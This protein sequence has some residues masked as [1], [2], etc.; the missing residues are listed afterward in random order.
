VQCATVLH[1]RT[2]AVCTLDAVVELGIVEIVETEL[3]FRH[4]L[5]RSA[6]RQAARPAQ[7]VAMYGALA[8]TVVDPERQL[9]HR[10][11]AAVG[12]DE[13]IAVALEEH[14]R[15]A[16]RRGAVAVAAAALERSA[17]LSLDP[18]RKG[19]R[20]VRAAEVVYELG[21]GDVVRRV[22]R[23]AEQLDLGLLEAARLAWL[24]QMISGDVWFETG[25]KTFVAI[26]WQMV[27]RGD[28]DM[29]LRS[30]VPIAHRC[31]WTRPRASTR[32]YLVEAAEEI[33]VPESDPRLLAVIALAHPE[34]T[35]PG[36]LR[37]V[38]ATKL[39][40]A[41][42]PL[43][44]MCLGIAA[45]KS[46]DFALGLPY[47]ARVVERLVS[48]GRSGCSRRRL[49]TTHG[50]RRTRAIGQR[51]LTPVWRRRASRSTPVSRSSGSRVS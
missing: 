33:G 36:V 45:E 32:R 47:L 12:G 17:A 19:E 46:G 18:R 4:P 7:L 28:A 22:I 20:L 9:W 38:S 37:H 21:R 6:V 41:V 10:A 42:D 1:G 3:P 39:H 11:M 14:T 2:V 30:L 5:M 31:W 23:Q 48:K 35:G 24:R 15:S 8:E 40:E 44:A 26:A 25:A 27:E 43:A 50:Q 16:R 13:E 34:M 49:C 29:A 51:P